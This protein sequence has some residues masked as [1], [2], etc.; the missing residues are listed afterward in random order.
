MKP[1]ATSI[2]RKCRNAIS[3][4][5]TASAAAN[6]PAISRPRAGSGRRRSSQLPA[7]AT[8]VAEATSGQDQGARAGKP[9]GIPASPTYPRNDVAVYAHQATAA[10]TPGGTRLSSGSGGVA[11]LRP[12]E[13]RDPRP[14]SDHGCMATAR[15]P[16]GAG[17]TDTPDPARATGGK[18]E[19]QLPKPK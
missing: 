6:E 19:R 15:R 14:A 7:S 11:G 4:E 9:C 1:R 12:S 13:P 2:A 5:F 16:P 10:H 3:T 17:G 8:V 18:D